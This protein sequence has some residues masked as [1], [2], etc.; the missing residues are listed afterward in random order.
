[1]LHRK[2]FSPLIIIVSIFLTLALVGSAYYVVNRSN[3][4]TVSTDLTTSTPSPKTDTDTQTPGNKIV[5][6]FDKSQIVFEQEIPTGKLI[7]FNTKNNV[8]RYDSELYFT[9]SN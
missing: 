8:D 9:E 7:V 4:D 5:T 6:P 2:G 1:M 3:V